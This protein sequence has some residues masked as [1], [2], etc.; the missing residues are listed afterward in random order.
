MNAT[1]TTY[2]AFTDERD[3]WF[4]SLDEA[5]KCV[6]EWRKEGFQNLRIYVEESEPG[7]DMVNEDCVYSEGGFPW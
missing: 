4:N 5:E 7:G 1:I 3:D 6:N 2:H